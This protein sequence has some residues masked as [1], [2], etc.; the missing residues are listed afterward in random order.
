ML[1]IG[2]KYLTSFTV[3]LLVRWWDV[4]PAVVIVALPLSLTDRMCIFL[5]VIV[6][7]FVCFCNCMCVFFVIVWFQDLQLSHWSDK[8]WRPPPPW[9]RHLLNKISF[10][11]PVTESQ[12]FARTLKGS[13]QQNK[14][15]FVCKE[16]VFVFSL[17]LLLSACLLY[18]PAGV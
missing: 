6:I 4:G 8:T 15:Q 7:V 13:L 17:Y 1:C 5:V 14:S 9:K 2:L 3:H 11:Q 12:W 10:A 16:F 18:S